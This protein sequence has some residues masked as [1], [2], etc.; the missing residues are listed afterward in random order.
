MVKLRNCWKQWVSSNSNAM[1][2]VKL[3][4][5]QQQ[6]LKADLHTAVLKCKI[7]LRTNEQCWVA[8]KWNVFCLESR[9]Y[10]LYNRNNI[11]IIQPWRDKST[12]RTLSVI[13]RILMDS[14]DTIVFLKSKLS[15]KKHI[16]VHN[17]WFSINWLGLIDNKTRY[18]NAERQDP[19]FVWL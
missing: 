10:I 16:P 18:Q 5:T 11:A 7:K 6:R 12:N 1:S 2:R 15:V 13:D 9:H 14:S 4:V 17:K 19:S 8:K 3:S